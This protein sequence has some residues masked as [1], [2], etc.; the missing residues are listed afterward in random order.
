[1]KPRQ[2]LSIPLNK[3]CVRHVDRSLRLLPIPLSYLLCSRVW[4]TTFICKQYSFFFVAG[5]LRRLC[6]VAPL[7]SLG[8]GKQAPMPFLAPLRGIYRLDESV[9]VSHRDFYGGET[10]FTLGIML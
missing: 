10:S 3:G 6:F 5:H 4:P 2:L 8:Y 1:M 7:L 9:N